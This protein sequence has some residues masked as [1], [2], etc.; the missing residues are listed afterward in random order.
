MKI[1][2]YTFE[3]FS[4]IAVTRLRK[5]NIEDSTARFIAEMVWNE[6]G[7]RDIRDVIKVARLVDSIQE[8]SLVVRMMKS[9]QRKF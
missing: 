1:P 7:S 2:E 9:Q 5:E 6:L 8:V 3:E 4:E